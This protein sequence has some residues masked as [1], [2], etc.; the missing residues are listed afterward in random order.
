MC[1]NKIKEEKVRSEW[2][3]QSEQIVLAGITAK[4]DMLKENLHFH[5]GFHRHGAALHVLSRTSSTTIERCVRPF[6]FHPQGIMYHT[7]KEV[8]QE[9]KKSSLEAEYVILIQCTLKCKEFCICTPEK[10]IMLVPQSWLCKCLVNK[11]AQTEP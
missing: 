5:H 4:R 11:V 10:K 9:L 2:A 8:P 7:V 3:N 1:K 6:P